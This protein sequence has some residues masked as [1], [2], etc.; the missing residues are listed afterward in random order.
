MRLSVLFLGVVVK[1]PKDFQGKEWLKPVSV[2]I[3]QR[4][5]AGLKTF[6]RLLKSKRSNKR[7]SDCCDLFKDSVNFINSGDYENSYQ[8]NSQ[9]AVSLEDHF[10]DEDLSQV[11]NDLE[12]YAMMLRDIAENQK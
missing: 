3:V 6:Q 7:V 10:V 1:D 4:I 12:R 8:A 2:E 9:C 11:A 5:Q